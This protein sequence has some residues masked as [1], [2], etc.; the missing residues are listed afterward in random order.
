MR[1]M[2]FITLPLRISWTWLGALVDWNHSLMPGSTHCLTSYRQ[3][4][5]SMTRTMP[6]QI[7]LY[8]LVTISS[9]LKIW[10]VEPECDSEKPFWVS[11]R[12]LTSR[13]HLIFVEWWKKGLYISIFLNVNMSSPWSSVKSTKL[14]VVWE[15]PTWYISILVS[16]ASQNAS[17]PAIWTVRSFI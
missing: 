12:F 8:D 14:A 15:R 5:L 1:D 16:C 10:D 2:V 9:W 17:L 11:M 4:F 7:W 6:L 13:S 3:K